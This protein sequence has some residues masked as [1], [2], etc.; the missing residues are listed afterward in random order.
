VAT[1]PALR[2]AGAK[3]AIFDLNKQTGEKLADELGATF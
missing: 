3:V 2:Q 1:V